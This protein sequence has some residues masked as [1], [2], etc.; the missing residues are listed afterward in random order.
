MTHLFVIFGR[1]LGS[2]RKI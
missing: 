1:D 2:F